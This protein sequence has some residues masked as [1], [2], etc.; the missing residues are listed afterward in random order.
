VSQ[1]IK[2]PPID[3]HAARLLG[4]L[5]LA[6]EHLRGADALS[7]LVEADVEGNPLVHR[8]F[9]DLRR[10]LSAARLILAALKPVGPAALP[11][12]DFGAIAQ[13]AM[14]RIGTLRHHKLELGST[15]ELLVHGDPAPL[16]AALVSISSL[17]PAGPISASVRRFQPGEIGSDK[18][19]AHHG[20]LLCQGEIPALSQFR[21]AFSLKDLRLAASS[22]AGIAEALGCILQHDGEIFA[23]AAKN[24]LALAIVL[25]ALSSGPLSGAADEA[26]QESQLK[27]TE[28]L[29]VVDDEDM[30]WDI[31]SDHLQELGYTVIL[32][33][34][35]LDAVETYKDNPGLFDLVILDMV[36][37]KMGG[38]EAF[39]EIRKIDPEARIIISSGYMAEGEAGDLLAA[40][41]CG[42]LR[43][44]YRIA[45]LARRIRQACG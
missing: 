31:L 33:E 23:A 14:R 7:E 6:A 2:D 20:I 38:R 36:M 3:D 45:E 44:P 17:L 1:S 4:Q 30:I 15:A 37:P 27:G 10:E 18:N 35:G 8:H 42:F 19:Q 5:R 9:L 41:A 24:Q 34:N 25:P 16:A 29:L 26:L 43:K 28:T 11:R 22:H 12:A 39:A 21:P 13:A 32:A 40:G